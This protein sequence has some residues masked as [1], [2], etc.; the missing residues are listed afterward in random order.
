MKKLVAMTV[1]ALGTSAMAQVVL[2]P[3][4]TTYTGFSRGFSFTAGS[5]FQITNLTLP[6]DA[7][8]GLTEETYLVDI[9]GTTAYYA[10]GPYAGGNINVT[11]GDIVTIVGNWTPGAAGGAGNFTAS[12]S[13]ASGGG[14]YSTMIEGVSTTLFRA[15]VQWDIG[16]PVGGPAALGT[17]FNGLSGSIGRINMYTQVP[18]PGSLALLGMG[19]LVAS[20]RRRG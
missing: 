18:A 6:T 8:A 1:L 16:D 3:H 7:Q 2:P 20:R 13:Y 5:S 12:N 11:A 4:A 9:N 14:T 19:G 17:I 10:N 15:G